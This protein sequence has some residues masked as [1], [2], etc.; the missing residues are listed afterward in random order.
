MPAIDDEDEYRGDGDLAQA[1]VS[2]QGTIEGWLYKTSQSRSLFQSDTF[3]KRY[4]RL[5]LMTEEL[6]VF[7]KPDGNLKSTVFLG[8]KI[9]QIDTE[10]NRSL[11]IEDK[12]KMGSIITLPEFNYPFIVNTDTETMLLWAETNHDRSLWVN[13]LTA[14]MQSTKMENLASFVLNK[15]KKN[16]FVVELMECLKEGY[17]AQKTT[18]RAKRSKTSDARSQRIDD[19]VA[20]PLELVDNSVQV[21]A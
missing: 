19:S 3:H 11:R 18:N 13:S 16:K 15:T 4:Y 20:T 6:K 12:R 2:A 8:K 9:M 21:K 17:H 7:N 10:L 14:L 5:N 1:F